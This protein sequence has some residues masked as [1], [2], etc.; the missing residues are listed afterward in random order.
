MKEKMFD[1]NNVLKN[2]MT[3]DYHL[4]LWPIKRLKSHILFK[5]EPQE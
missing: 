5:E 2:K 1:E 3:Q 4:S